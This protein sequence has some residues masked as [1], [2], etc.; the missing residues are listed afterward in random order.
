[1][2]R[3]GVVMLLLVALPGCRE[4]EKDDAVLRELARLP[5]ATVPDGGTQLTREEVR[6]GGSDPAGIA[7]ASAIRLTYA[8]SRPPEQVSAW[9][10]REYDGTWR[11]HDNGY[12]PGGGV[13]LVGALTSDASTTVTVEAREST[14][15]DG[16]PEGSAS[17]VSLSVAR[18][19]D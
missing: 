16:V 3:L 2:L 10:H 7:G 5:I 12:A 6:G 13:A 19:R 18:T 17:V 15:S 8:T 4:E 14:A 11:L 9:Y 1:M